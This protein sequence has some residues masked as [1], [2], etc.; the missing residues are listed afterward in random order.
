MVLEEIPLTPY[1]ESALSWWFKREHWAPQAS[2]LRRKALE[3]MASERAVKETLALNAAATDPNRIDTSL[4]AMISEWNRRRKLGIRP[5]PE[6]DVMEQ[7][8]G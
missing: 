3:L 5:D 4:P 7:E 2:D 8:V 6:D 1:L